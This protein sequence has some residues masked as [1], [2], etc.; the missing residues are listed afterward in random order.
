MRLTSVNNDRVKDITKLIKSAKRRRESRSFV[1]EGIR[2]VSEVPPEKLISLY[3]E[4]TFYEKLDKSQDYDE[5]DF[6]RGFRDRIMALIKAAEEKESFFLVNDAVMNKLSDTETPQGILAVV[7][8]Q[9]M[10]A[11]NLLT[12]DDMPFI[13]VMDGLQDPGNM[14]TIIRTAEG[15][16]VTGIL[17]S[18]DSVDPYSPKV[19]RAAM[20]ALFRMK[21]CIS[22]DLKEDISLLKEKGITVFGTHLSGKEFYDE[23]FRIPSAFLIGNE[24]KGLKDDVAETADRLLRIPMKGRVESLNAGV[25]AA[26][27]M[28]EV[29]RQRR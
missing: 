8:M 3:I 25:S 1:A 16:G 18:S 7:E 10:E 14:G 29:L 13:I 2:L 12:D 17:I 4:E 20:G 26:V 19:V 27:V 5:S 24:G 21:L 22:T 6:E 28:Y 11:E 23:D 9:D 15:A